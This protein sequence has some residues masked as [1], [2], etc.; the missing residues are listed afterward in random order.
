MPQGEGKKKGAGI[1]VF[2]KIGEKAKK[3]CL[4]GGGGGG[5]VWLKSLNDSA[6]WENHHN[7]Q[8]TL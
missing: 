2:F 3:T 6:T 8:K 7:P 4:G 5:G 1:T